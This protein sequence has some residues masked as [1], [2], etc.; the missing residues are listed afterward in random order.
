MDC[1]TAVS[2]DGFTC[3]NIVSAPCWE[4]L[5]CHRLT[6]SLVTL[7]HRPYWDHVRKQCETRGRSVQTS[8]QWEPMSLLVHSQPFLLLKNVTRV[9]SYWSRCSPNR[10]SLDSLHW[11][12]S[13]PIGKTHIQRLHL[14]AGRSSQKPA[15]RD[16]LN[17][18]S[19]QKSQTSGSVLPFLPS[20][21][22][23]R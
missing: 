13:F 15:G 2:S 16:I 22:A 17:Q 9:R 6:G 19:P 8:P 1:H 12:L 23:F 21:H 5:S 20:D 3:Y 7:L 14:Q 11:G 4:I 18:D 10:Q